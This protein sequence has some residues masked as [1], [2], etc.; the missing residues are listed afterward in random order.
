M[1][2]TG[3]EAELYFLNNYQSVDIFKGGEIEDARLYGDGY[4]FQ[5]NVSERFLLA[6]VKGVRGESGSLR[7][8]ENEYKKATEYRNDYILSVVLN[9]NDVP[10]LKMIRNPTESLEFKKVEIVSK[11]HIEYQSVSLVR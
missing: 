1:Q 3:L 2:E 8:T 9:L 11:A 7:F 6:E 4:D 5:I 10:V